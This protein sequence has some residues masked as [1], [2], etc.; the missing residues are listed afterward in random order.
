MIYVLIALWRCEGHH[1]RLWNCD[2]KSD[3]PSVVW[4]VTYCGYLPLKTGNFFC[5]WFY[6]GPPYPHFC[7]LHFGGKGTEF[8][9][10]NCSKPLCHNGFPFCHYYT[11][12][13]HL[14]SKQPSCGGRHQDPAGK[15]GPLF[16]GV[17]TGSLRSRDRHHAPRISKQD[18]G[19]HREN[20]MIGY[21]LGTVWVFP[22]IEKSEPLISQGFRGA[23]NRT[24]TNKDTGIQRKLRE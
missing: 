11:L 23:G 14:R 9:S 15:H 21:R 8:S 1:S 16:R 7:F 6:M 13:A 22:H 20:G 3:V 24:W 17:H 5:H 12:M 4:G 19:L 2:W 18:A 10:P